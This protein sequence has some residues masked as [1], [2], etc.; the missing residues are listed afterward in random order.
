MIKEKRF[1]NRNDAWIFLR[2]CD[3]AG[4]PVG[5]PHRPKGEEYWIVKYIE[6]K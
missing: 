1:E 5:F 3:K 4:V 6:K 2:D